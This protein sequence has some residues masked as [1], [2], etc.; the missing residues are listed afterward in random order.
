[1]KWQNDQKESTEEIEGAH[2][3]LTK[4][5][6]IE[7]SPTRSG[8]RPLGQTLD[9]EAMTCLYHDFFRRPVCIG[10]A[11]QISTQIY[12]TRLTD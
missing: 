3:G 5:L 4:V 12:R 2:G 6:R 8:N 10:L 7:R 11:E 1:M 9:L